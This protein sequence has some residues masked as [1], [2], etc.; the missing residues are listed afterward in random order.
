[1]MKTLLPKRDAK[2]T[3]YSRVLHLGSDNSVSLLIDWS[4]PALFEVL[5]FGRC[6]AD[7]TLSFDFSLTI[8]NTMYAL[9]DFLI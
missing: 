6:H 3:G 5:L 1:M 2:R 9:I 7:L 4:S 8:L